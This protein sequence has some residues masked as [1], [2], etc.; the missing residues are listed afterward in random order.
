MPGRQY[1]FGSD[2]TY[3]Y[4]FNGKENDNSVK[5]LGN[6]QD[7]GE[8]IYDTRLG[9]FLSVDPLIDNYPELSSYQFASNTPIQSVDLDGKEEINYNLLLSNEGKTTLQFVS[10]KDY[11]T[12]FGF[13][14][15][16][17]PERYV[18]NYGGENYYIGFEGAY[19][20]G[21]TNS[22]PL[23]KFWK[24]NLKDA[25]SFG[26]L[27]FSERQ[28]Y[29]GALNK[30]VNEL[31]NSLAVLLFTGYV[32]NPGGAKNPDGTN[33][34]KLGQNGTQLKST[35]VW[36]EKGSSARIDVENPALED[37][38]GSLH[39]QDAKGNKYQ[40]SVDLNTFFGENPQTGEFDANAPKSVNDLLKDKAFQKGI[41]KGLSYL[42][43]KPAD[44]TKI[45]N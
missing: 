28:S 4:G 44:F 37:R 2:S 23:F 14:I 12:L 9:R 13:K 17:I 39:Y 22:V 20:T 31:R 8:R 16:K 18:I 19:G 38:P 26:G 25:A 33:Y 10:R 32:T 43:E 29:A 36:K 41:N 30:E 40:Y 7:Y 34:H 24:A 3:R 45:S 42:G 15:G 1:T 27:F 35:T 6:Q 11:N 5:G 21:N